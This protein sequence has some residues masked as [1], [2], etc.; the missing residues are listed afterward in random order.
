[1]DGYQS[2]QSKGWSLSSYSESELLDPVN[3]E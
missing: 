1:M 3:E 2:V